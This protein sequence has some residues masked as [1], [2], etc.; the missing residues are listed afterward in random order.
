[1]LLAVMKFVCRLQLAEFVIFL[2]VMS[3]LVLRFV[4]WF[5]EFLLRQ[6]RQ[7]KWHSCVWFQNCGGFFLWLLFQHV[8]CTFDSSA[9]V[10]MMITTNVCITIT[11]VM[12]TKFISRSR[13]SCLDVYDNIIDKVRNVFCSNRCW[14]CC[15]YL[16]ILQ[17]RIS[18]LK[19]DCNWHWR[20]VFCFFHIHCCRTEFVL[21]SILLDI[22]TRHFFLNR[23]PDLKIDFVLR[24]YTVFLILHIQVL[25]TEVLL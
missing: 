18:D 13:N 3:S 6:F 5:S 17:K 11:T 8:K 2:L 4:L 15:Y 7:L 9:S 25:R 20:T 12:S 21:Y 14:W 22:D 24:W 10:N 23:V 19:I 16:R 1:M